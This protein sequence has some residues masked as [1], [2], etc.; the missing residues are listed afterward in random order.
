MYIHKVKTKIIQKDEYLNEILNYSKIFQKFR[1][2]FVVVQSDTTL[3]T[4]IIYPEF[5]FTDSLL[6]EIKSRQDFIVK[7]R[8]HFPESVYMG[9]LNLKKYLDTTKYPDKNE[10]NQIIET[11]WNK[12][13]KDTL[14]KFNQAMIDSLYSSVKIQ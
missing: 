11:N 8:K 1:R 6:T 5:I 3:N 9:F 4:K 7:K 12:E 13:R 14:I 10:L 2:V